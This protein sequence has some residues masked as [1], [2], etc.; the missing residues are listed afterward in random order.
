MKH[1]VTI[2]ALAIMAGRL[3]AIALTIGAMAGCASMGPSAAPVK[4]S[5]SNP[6]PLSDLPVIHGSD[7]GGWGASDG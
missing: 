3:A 1:K 4:S 6:T 2:G 7:D 5:M